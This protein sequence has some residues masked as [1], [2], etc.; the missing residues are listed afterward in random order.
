MI[1]PRHLITLAIA[2]FVLGAVVYL[3]FWSLT[4]G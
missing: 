4:H 3:Q 1:R 2:C